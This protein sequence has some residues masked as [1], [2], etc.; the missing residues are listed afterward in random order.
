MENPTWVYHATEEAKIVSGEEAAELYKKG[1]CDCPKKAKET[2]SEPK[3]RG[4]K[5]KK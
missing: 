5:A 2:K 4:A 1:W 3:K